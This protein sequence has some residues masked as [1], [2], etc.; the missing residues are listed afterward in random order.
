MRDEEHCAGGL[1]LVK[2]L[3]NPLLRDRVKRLCGLVQDER[4]GEQARDSYARMTLSTSLAQ[5]TSVVL[6]GMTAYM[7]SRTG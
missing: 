2:R 7:G 3:L 4:A 5:L 6:S 1:K